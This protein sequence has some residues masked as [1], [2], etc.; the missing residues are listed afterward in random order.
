[1]LS[2]LSIFQ[3]QLVMILRNLAKLCQKPTRRC[4][5]CTSKN[6]Q[7]LLQTPGRHRYI[8]IIVLH[9]FMCCKYQPIHLP[10]LSPLNISI[11][12]ENMIA[13]VARA[14]NEGFDGIFDQ[15]FSGF[16]S[17]ATIKYFHSETFRWSIKIIAQVMD[18]LA[19]QLMIKTPKPNY[20]FM[21]CLL[22]FSKICL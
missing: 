2:A 11:I 15:L 3:L 21:I 18:A 1:M 5:N 14:N 13:V 12:V 17:N 16:R 10:F 8:F 6:N 9:Y 22:E 7:S 20:G 4:T 19:H